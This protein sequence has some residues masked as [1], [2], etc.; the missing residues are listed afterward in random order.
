MERHTNHIAAGLAAALALPLAVLALGMPLV[1]AVPLS[2]ALYAGVA[3]AMAPRARLPRVDFGKIGR[4]Q[5]EVVAELIVAADGEVAA[6]ETAAKALHAPDLRDP[7][8]RLAATAR[9]I[10]DRLARAPEKLPAARR[11]LAYYLPRSVEIANSLGAVERRS[12]Q[13]PSR[14]AAIVAT[15]GRLDQAFGVTADGLDQ[16]DIAALDVELRLL[17]KALAEDLGPLPAAQPPRRA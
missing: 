8:A 7:V 10:L 17:D 13:E 2:G 15:L 9:T 6:L 5:A 3:L 12:Q 1:I 11:F 14:R 4:A 16:G